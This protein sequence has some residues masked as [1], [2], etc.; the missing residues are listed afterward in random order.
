MSLPFQSAD[1]QSATFVQ[2]QAFAPVAETGVGGWQEQTPLA[3]FAP[4][5][6]GSY[7]MSAYP[8]LH[9]ERDLL[10]DDFLHMLHHP[11]MYPVAD[12]YQ[13][14][15][16]TGV[17]ENAAIVPSTADSYQPTYNTGVGE[18]A[19][20]V[21]SITGS[22][23]R[24]HRKRKLEFKDNSAVFDPAWVRQLPFSDLQSKAEAKKIKL[25]ATLPYGLVEVGDVLQV[26]TVTDQGGKLSQEAQV[27]LLDLLYT[28]MSH[29]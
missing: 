23:S 20:M 10:S 28:R 4:Y 5:T 8:N 13:P 17:V 25:S 22:S 19:E 15:Y 12:S 3:S 21:L 9:Y 26:S 14:T 2:D 1:G 6:Y 27:N 16:N 18:D 29:V 24:P 11:V 7:L